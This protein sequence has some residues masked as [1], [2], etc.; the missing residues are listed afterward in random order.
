MKLR[1]C[2]KHAFNMVLHSKL[3]SWL[4]ILGIVIGVGSVIAIMSI[5]SG[6]QEQINQ[7]MGGLGA[8]I[9]T[10]TAGS[11]RG[12]RMFGVGGGGDGP[13][14]MGGG[15]AVAEEDEPVLDNSDIQALKSIPE[16]ELINPTISGS[17][18]AA[19]LGKSGSVQ[20]TG[21]D[22]AVWARITTE[23]IDQ[24]RM[25]DSADQ[26]VIVIGGRLASSYFDSPVGINQKLTLTYEN[27]SSIFRVVGIID[28]NSNSIYIPIQMAFQVL[29]DKE[30]DEYDS[31]TIKIEDENQLDATMAK[32]EKKLMLVRHV[33][34]S[35]KDFSL[36]SS[37]KM[38][39]TM[40]EMRSTMSSFL[41][42][43]AA[44]SL[45]V[46]AIGIANT[47]FTSVLEKTKDIGIMKAIGARNRDILI[48][49]LLNA[50]LIGLVGGL[51]GVIFGGILSGVLPALMGESGMLRGGTFVSLNSVLMALGVSVSVG[52][53][54]GAIPAYKGSKLRPVDA[55]R[56]E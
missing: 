13:P 54:A 47:M 51:L 38:E 50:M 19:Y 14:G 41:V 9:L 25:L 42:A 8:D 30:K 36:T 24:G 33:T 5:G 10:L 46:G 43:I 20:L 3:R 22:Q 27:K 37:A 31:I 7:Q 48:I 16:I 52:L 15:S 56:Y 4:T 44:V 17:V 2:L 55:L 26:N 29:S 28:D 45:I 53:A 11:S 1:K 35:T 6:M 34:N 40:S 21:V 49:F 32:I 39:E 12:V 18:K 23:E